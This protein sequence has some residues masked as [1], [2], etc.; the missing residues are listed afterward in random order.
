MATLTICGLGPGGE[1]HLTAETLTRIEAAE[2]RFVRTSRHPTAHLVSDA[3]SF[4]HL[5]ETAETFDHVY[6]A[7]TDAL[8]AATTAAGSALYAVPGSPLV[9]EETVRRLRADTRIGVELVPAM[10]FL[11]VAWARLG[12]D[13][14]DD[15]VRLIDGHRFTHQAAGER[16]PL[17]VAHAHAPWVLSD[18]KLAI[19]AGPE[20]RAVVLQRLGTP[21]E[22]IVEVAWPDLDRV[23]EPDH[24]TSIYLPTVAAPVAQELVSTVQLMHRLR[25]ECPWDQAQDHASLRSYL[26]EETYELLEAI[27]DVAAAAEGDLAPYELLEE[28]LGDVWFQVLFHAEL[29]T[30]V[31]AFTI[32]DVARTVHDK[33]VSRHPHVFGETEVDGADQVAANW[34]KIKKAEKQRTSALDG[35]PAGLPSLA[36]AAKTLQRAERA[37]APIEPGTGLLAAIADD[38]DDVTL[39]RGLLATVAAARA[40]DL[41][42]E[43]ALR[44]AVLA[45]QERFRAQERS[46]A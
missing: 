22:S 24:L 13:P 39:G 28:E 32:A 17:L 25:Q 9:L 38:L 35:I 36:L 46:G 31:G 3:T 19:D 37:G 14:V 29:A 8:V 21:E 15:G 11:D 44:R 18:I 43:D 5:Y 7:I 4:D 41:D 10:S 16:G 30:E 40:A 12:V 26:L 23:V 2:Q 27:D 20:Q 1:H 34:E 45:A 42:P 6:G 33:L